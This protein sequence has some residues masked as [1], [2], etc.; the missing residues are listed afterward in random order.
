MCAHTPRGGSTP[1]HWARKFFEPAM[2]EAFA[3]G[4]DIHRTTAASIFGVAPDLVG[5]DQRRAAKTINFGLIYGMSAFGLANRLG[6]PAKE[7]EQFIA[8]YFARFGG[9]QEYMRAT[10]EAAERTL[11][12]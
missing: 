3:R 6:I 1:T 4:E 9:V 2:I 8:A 11:R 12:A 5:A 7:A 10:L